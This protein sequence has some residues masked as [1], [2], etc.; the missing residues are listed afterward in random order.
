[1]ITL[2]QRVGV[3]ICYMITCLQLMHFSMQTLHAM[4]MT[5]GVKLSVSTVG[6]IPFNSIR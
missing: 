6:F 2:H 5:F 1:M 3:W 4:M